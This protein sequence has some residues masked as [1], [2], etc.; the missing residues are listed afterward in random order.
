MVTGRAAGR[1][2]PDQITFYR[3]LGNQG[4]QFASVGG[5][6]YDKAMA[7]GTARALPTEWFLQDIRD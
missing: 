7:A 6:L 5:L 4:L 3:N 2:S 1:T